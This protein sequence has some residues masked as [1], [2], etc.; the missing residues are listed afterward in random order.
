M[1]KRV[2]MEV[3]LLLQPLPLV[4]LDRPVTHFEIRFDLEIPLARVC[5][6]VVA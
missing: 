2:H 6:S 4:V 3:D 1:F 5:R